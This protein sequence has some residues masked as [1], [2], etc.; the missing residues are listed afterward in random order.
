MDFIKKRDLGIGACR[1][2]KDRARLTW[3]EIAALKRKNIQLYPSRL[4]L[5]DG[6]T[7]QLQPDEAAPLIALS[8]D[9]RTQH[10]LFPSMVA[11]DMA[12]PLAPERIRRLGA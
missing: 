12:E 4:V 5:D 7:I 3:D 2:F 8:K 6:R 9:P 11:K 1:A 10:W